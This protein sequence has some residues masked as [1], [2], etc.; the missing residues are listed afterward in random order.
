[1]SPT[2]TTTPEPDPRT[3]PKDSVLFERRDRV[4]LVTL[5]RPEVLNAVNAELSWRCGEIL[6]EI[7]QDPE[8]WA[9]V[10]TGAG[11]RAFCVGAD[12]RDVA[13]RPAGQHGQ[14]PRPPFGFAGLTR[15]VLAKPIIAAVN[16]YAV[17]GGLEAALA[18]DLIVASKTATFGLSEVK[19]GMAA[20][21]GGLLRL[22]RQ[23]PVRMA[24][25][26]ALTGD[27]ISAA[28]AWR[29][30]LVNRV[31]PPGSLMDEA[32]GLAERICANAPLAVR[33]AKRI[34]YHG[35][36]APLH[37][38]T[39]AWDVS[40]RERRLVSES[41]D[42]SEGPRAFVEKRPPVWTGR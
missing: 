15:H 23:I 28:E 11:D 20:G 39:T 13:A 4:A 30:G 41:D 18:C 29:L 33:A 34:I 25:E 21:G 1:M 3:G 38:V 36:E 40:D 14:A 35:L 2:P 12:L 16:G 37:D 9:V 6:E 26:M 42:A 24:M 5:N 7:E 19:R 10:I 8:L 17:G 31:V 32:L 22:P 27:T